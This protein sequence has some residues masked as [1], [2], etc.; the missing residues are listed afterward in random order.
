MATQVIQTTFENTYKDD[1]RDSDN[2]YKVLF[3]NGRALQQRELNT[4]QSI[5]QSD[6]KTNSDFIFRH[7]SAASGGGISSQNQKDFIK[8]NQ[9]TNALPTTATSIEGIVFTEAS[10]GIKFRVD[11]VTVAVGS[12]PAVLHVTYTDNGS[13]D[14]GTAGLLV[15]PGFNFTGTDSTTLTTQTTNTVANPATGFGTLLTV[16]PG[17]FYIDGHFVFT[18]LQSLVVSKFTSTPDATIGFVVTEEIYTTDDDNDLFDNSGATLNTASPGADRYRVTLTLIDEANIA[19]GDYFIPVVEMTDG[20]ISK[21]EGVTAAASGLESMLAVRTDEESGSYTVGRMLTDFETNADSATKVDMIIGGGTAYVNGFRHKSIGPLSITVQKPRT[22]QTLNNSASSFSFGN[23]VKITTL[24]GI[25][26]VNTFEKVDLRDAVTYGGNTIGTARVRAIEEDGSNYR[27]YL[28]DIALN[29]NKNFGMVRSI[30]KSTIIYG[31]VDLLNTGV[32]NAGGNVALLQ[33]QT[34]NNLFFPLSK[35]RAKSISDIVITVQRILTGTADGSGNL[36]LNA[37]TL[38]G[39]GHIWADASQWFATADDDGVVDGNAVFTPASDGS[40]IA[41]TGLTASQAHTIVGYAQKGNASVKAKTLT[42][43]A[44]ADFTPASDGSINLGKTDILDVTTIKDVRGNLDGD[45]S[46]RYTLDNGSRDNFYDVG[47]L[48]LKSGAVAPAGN[49]EVAFRHFAH[50]ADGDF[51]AVNSYSGQVDYEDIPSHRQ[52]NGE[53]IQLRDVLDFRPTRATEGLNFHTGTSNNI[54]RLPKN[55]DLVT[56]DIEHYLGQ[57]AISFINES[58]DIGLEI[59]KAAENPDYP[60]IASS[61]LKLARVHLFPYM[62]DDDDLYVE[63]LDNRRYTMRDIG[64]IEKRLD[65]LEESVALNMLELETTNLDVFDSSGVN[66]LKAGITADNF[67][68]HFQSDTTLADYRAAIDPAMGELRPKFVAR[69]IGLIFDSAASSGCSLTGDKV[70][71]SYTEAVYQTQNNASRATAVNPYG[72]ERMTGTIVMSPA[73]DPWY[74]Q[75]IISTRITKG[76]TSFSLGEGQTF[77]DWDFNWSGVTEDQVANFKTGDIIGER[78]VNG[79]SYQN[80]NGNTTT[81]YQRRTSQAFSVSGMSTVREV[82]DSRVKSSVAIPYIRSRFISFKCTG[83]RPNSQVFGFFDGIN[84]STFMNTTAGTGAFVRMG[85]LVKTSPYLEVDNI[86]SAAT[87]Y[88]AGLGGATTKMV[89]DANGA[90][91]GYFLLPRTSA[92]K[93]KTGQKIFTLLDI[94]AFNPHNATTIAEFIYEANGILQDIDQDVLDT[95]VIQYSSHSSQLADGVTGSY[96]NEDNSGPV[97][98]IHK[99]KGM[100]GSSR[101]KYKNRQPVYSWQTDADS[102]DMDDPSSGKKVIC[103]ALHSLGLLSNDIYLLDRQY[104]KMLNSTDPALG[105]G[106]RLWATPIAEYIKGDSMGSKV[107]RHIVAP[108]ATAWAEEMAHQM[109][110]DEYKSNIIGK[111]LMAVGYPIC[112]T[113]GEYMNKQLRDNKERI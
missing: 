39:S 60:T 97:F 49:V 51:F 32:A 54:N 50:G 74:E 37:A 6:F 26:L 87:T 4:L 110:P 19:S 78:I 36:T 47:K 1:F 55:N 16:A 44:A 70:M 72:S 96:S 14:G 56:Y 104:G 81:T 64:S 105:N 89:T 71:L 20:R 13:G 108:V 17:K 100:R 75:N 9:T 25:P 68:N 91:S 112:R 45:I 93:F 90:I 12:D 41:I 27:F 106:Y 99:N 107:A 80:N 101:G 11:K 65:Q 66:R 69:P 43:V 88:P 77:G 58:G 94:S 22:T 109:R 15:T 57:K 67:R 28:F 83:L 33:D 5:I 31:D 84:V 24:K 113:I 48:I 29:A 18:A 3:N 103:T 42:A 76:D 2:Y 61:K 52:A 98:K 23:F 30:G 46:D 111:L 95:R 73:S 79:G 86:Y 8:L 59:G 82:T 40:T 35:D 10:T 34:N 38:L 85:T 21:Q 53:R 63:Q 102:M 92:I 7:G 62:L